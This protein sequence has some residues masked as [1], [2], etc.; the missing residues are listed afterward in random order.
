MKRK[1]FKKILDLLLFAV[2]LLFC[3]CSFVFSEI[4]ISGKIDPLLSGAYN[5]LYA[6]EKTKRISQD[7]PFIEVALPFERFNSTMALN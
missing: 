2:F 7:S 6:P 4:K 5:S 3:L 1:H